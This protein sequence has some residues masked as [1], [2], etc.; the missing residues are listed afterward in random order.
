[1]AEYPAYAVGDD[2]RFISFEALVGADDADAIEKAKR[3]FDGHAIELWSGDRFV[4]RLN[5]KRP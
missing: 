2:G 1:M 3:L 5:R 4:V